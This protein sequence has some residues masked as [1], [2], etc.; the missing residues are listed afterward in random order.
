MNQTPF[1]VKHSTQG[2]RYLL[3]C[4]GGSFSAH[5][6]KAYTLY[7]DTVVYVALTFISLTL[8]VKNT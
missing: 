6:L 8:Q 5:A 2:P 7:R 4:E 3:F 1:A